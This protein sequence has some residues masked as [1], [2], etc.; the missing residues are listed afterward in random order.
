MNW[1]Y[2]LTLIVFFTIATTNISCKEDTYS[3]AKNVK[4]SNK[5]ESLE[6]KD[7]FSS[8]D[9]QG[10]VSSVVNGCVSAITGGYF[11]SEVEIYMPGPV[12]IYFE[13]HYCSLLKKDSYWKFNNLAN[14][15]L[16]KHRNDLEY[17]TRYESYYFSS[18][19][20][21]LRCNRYPF[22]KMHEKT[23]QK[24]FKF[25]PDGF[26][27]TNNGPI[28]ARTNEAN[29]ILLTSQEWGG[30]LAEILCCDG[31]RKT[32]KSI[33]LHDEY[34]IFRIT[35]HQ[36]LNNGHIK[37]SIDDE[38]K[39]K[40]VLAYN[41]RLGTEYSK[42]SYKYDR[43]YTQIDKI[44]S[45][46]GRVVECKMKNFSNSDKNLFIYEVIRPNAK[47]VNYDYTG[48]KTSERP[49]LSSK[50]YPDK[51]YLNVEYYTLGE[52]VT[53]VSKVKI[54]DKKDKRINRVK[55]LKAPLGNDSTPVTQF[56]FL[57]DLKQD[58]ERIFGVTDVIDA[59]NHQTR[60]VFDSASR[61][62]KIIKYQGN[63]Y[64]SNR[65]YFT[66]ELSWYEANDK[67]DGYL[68]QKLLKDSNE[69][70]YYLRKYIYDDRGNIIKDY[71]FGNFSGRGQSL[72]S[73]YKQ[74]LNSVEKYEKQFE[75]S[76]DGLNLLRIEKDHNL[77]IRYYY[78]TKSDLVTQK[79]TTDNANTLFKREFFSYDDNGIL[80]KKVV[81]DGCRGREEDLQGV[82]ERRITYITPKP[83]KPC[84]GL[85][86][87]TEEYCLD[88]T[89]G[90]EKL[91]HKTTKEYTREGWVT[92]EERYDENNELR[93]TLLWEYDS[94]GNVIAETDAYGYTIHRSY[95]A[96]DNLI[97]EIS[98]LGKIITKEYDFSNRVISS[99][100]ISDNEKL[101]TTFKYDLKG[102]CVSKTDPYG[103]TTQYVY[104][105]FD[106]LVD[107]YHP[108][109]EDEEGKIYQPRESK[110][111]DMMDNVETE[112]D[113][114]GFTISKRY[115]ILKKPY[116]IQ[117]PDGTS[118]SFEYNL[119]GS[120]TKSIAKNGS[121]NL[122]FYDNFDRLLKQ[123]TYSKDKVLL[124]E[125]TNT[126]NSLRLVSSTDAMGYVTTYKYDYAGRKIRETCGDHVT[127]YEYDS[128]GRLCKT[129]EK[130][131]DGVSDYT[132]KVVVYDLTD[133]V[134]EERIESGYGEVLQKSGYVYDAGGNK[135]LTISYVNDCPSILK[136]D[137][138]SF[139]LPKKIEDALGNEKY[140]KYD[141]KG[142]GL[143]KIEIDSLG[144]QTIT[145]LDALNR[146]VSIAK[147][148]LSGVETSKKSQFFDASGNRVKVIDTVIT[149][150]R[151]N[152]NVITK[153]EHDTSGK[154][155]KIFEAF[156]SQDQKVTAFKYDNMGQKER[157]VKPDGVIIA[158]EYDNLSRLLRYY[159]T[160][161][162]FDYSYEYNLNGKPIS[163]TDNLNKSITVFEYDQNNR[164]VKET[165]GNGLALAY[166]YDYKDRPKSMSLPDCSRVEYSYDALYLKEVKRESKS[167]A[168]SHQYTK[169][170]LAG[171]LLESN[172]VEDMGKLSISYDQLGREISRVTD[173]FKEDQIKYD[174]MGNVISIDFEDNISLL[175]CD[176]QYDDLYQI[177]SE[178]GV[179][180]H[181]YVFDS[182][183][184]RIYKDTV[185]HQ[186]NDLNQILCQQG[187]Q[188]VYDTCGNMLS[189]SNKN[190][191]YSY[192][193][194]DRLVKVKK[195][196]DEI[197]YIYDSLNRRL[198]KIVH[199][200]TKDTR[201]DY[202]YQGQNEIGVYQDGKLTELRVLGMGKGAEIG[203]AVALEIEDEVIVPIHDH[204]GN[205]REI[206]DADTHEVIETYRYSS[207]GEEKIFN[208][209]G[210]EETKGINPWRFSSKRYDDETGFVY[211]GRRY[212][213]PELG[214]WLNKD[215]IGF[216]G[217]P[218]LYAYVFNSPLFHLDLY[219][220]ERITVNSR[221]HYLGYGLNVVNNQFNPIPGLRQAV[222]GVSRKMCGMSWANDNNPASGVYNRV[223]QPN[224]NGAYALYCNGINTDYEDGLETIDVFKRCCGLK[225]IEYS[226]NNN[227][228][229]LFGGLYNRCIKMNLINNKFIE[230]QSVSALRVEVMRLN[231][232]INDGQGKYIHIFSFS[233]GATTAFEATYNLPQSIRD[234]IYH[235]TFGG[236]KTIPYNKFGDAINHIAKYDGVAQTANILTPYN[237]QTDKYKVVHLPGGFHS[238]NDKYYLQCFKKFGEQYKE[239]FRN[240]DN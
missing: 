2:A 225:N 134:L 92:K 221:W 93:Y 36:L 57:Y 13:R 101:L 102:N 74:M 47:K 188:Y 143:K 181:T 155:T 150:N 107:T 199:L 14:I 78:K 109:V 141:Y 85:P 154:V 167:K 100:E 69:I 172:L 196:E 191:S 4:A 112:T 45:S 152:R 182:L 215:P 33:C 211:F 179:A 189:D 116:Y 11:D 227:I 158:Q 140:I 15:Q 80:T 81:D 142:K 136:I 72:T 236:A 223:S 177:K 38:Y 194:L 7:S 161:D 235:Y 169:F 184:N 55:C 206:Y 67:L 53:Q 76:N 52:N 145:Q 43:K 210:K 162:S 171:N 125:I 190:I 68:N 3:D 224:D 165:L 61:L 133:R 228:G 58:D 106:R 82:T 237:S 25:C 42:L 34:Q 19:E 73:N 139:N 117:Y 163:I 18:E 5:P 156:K 122:Y 131:G 17:L 205:V 66:T 180:Q 87:S 231:E 40:E 12:P 104:D 95:D 209:E 23:N 16:I 51:R 175:K 83:D 8:K 219:G 121:Y 41:N 220:L 71:L 120:C 232:L 217:G 110:T 65:V 77:T 148:N 187:I 119:K 144:N 99:C 98:P 239:T 149:P 1:K 234:R 10:E 178:T 44:S 146:I 216:D 59:L 238:T 108:K 204:N 138:D 208:R 6:S 135:T 26:C 28:S 91:L 202:L 230:S 126:Y 103:N 157:I 164:L 63:T 50:I 218:N 185:E 70:V 113:G 64:G 75:Y 240:Y 151:K 160:D 24:S 31:S 147:N 118:E 195:D 170:D 37:Y 105:E 114:R 79:F 193:A 183:N 159:G 173:H 128:L 200:P 94:H 35:D 233:H 62:N 201:Y 130:Y 176:Y 153:W 137:Y 97:T 39:I 56:T 132:V 203:G 111:Y 212:Y 166:E 186:V 222:N 124:Q 32:F 229:V 197:E 192:D 90:K 168:Y 129:K 174:R 22:L 21:H 96:N 48:Y 226:Y 214:R 27:N 213:L 30:S 60:Y 123:Q 89:T 20:S 88:L 9:Y 127:E 84:L 29:N 198:S 115:T 54:T 86:T 46:D 207:F 49:L